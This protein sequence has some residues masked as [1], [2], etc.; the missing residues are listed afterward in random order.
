[1][2]NSPFFDFFGQK[3]S[4]K[5]TR[6]VSSQSAKLARHFASSLAP[7]SVRQLP[8]GPSP[9]RSPRALRAAASPLRGT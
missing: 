8:S 9:P 5:K 3:S 7:T 4:T 6:A 1:M 2:L